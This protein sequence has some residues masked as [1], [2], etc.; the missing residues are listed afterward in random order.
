MYRESQKKDYT[1]LMR[2]LYTILLFL[3][4]FVDKAQ[5]QQISYIETTKNWYYIYDESGKKIK[6]FST[7][8]G[9]LKGY[10]SS[11]FVVQS[12][13]WIYVYDAKGNKIKTM[14]ESSAG[15]VLSV[16]GDTFTT[17]LGSWIYTWSKEGKKISTRYKQK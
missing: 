15:K 9:E 14:S 5:C 1:E 12:G 4:A 6:T 13:S 16:S 11:I 2:Q 3:L 17:Q 7:N 8:I 10:S